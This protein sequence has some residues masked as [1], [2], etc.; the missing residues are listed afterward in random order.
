MI[1]LFYQTRGIM[2]KN[3]NKFLKLGIFII[4]VI[5]LS[6]LLFSVLIS[7]L[8]TK[9]RMFGDGLILRTLNYIDN[10]RLITKLELPSNSTHS[11]E[12][13][14][15]K[16]GSIA[17][18]QLRVSD[19][20]FTE[21]R[22]SDEFCRKKYTQLPLDLEGSIFQMDKNGE[23]IRDKNGRSKIRVTKYMKQEKNNNNC[24]NQ[25]R[26][27]DI[28]LL[29]KNNKKQTLFDSKISDFGGQ[30]VKVKK[31]EVLY[32]TIN[33]KIPQDT[34]VAPMHHYNIYLKLRAS[35]VLP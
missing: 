12:Y 35:T 32:I 26:Y 18:Y 33:T 19:F 14:A 16:K 3:T 31:D 1:S 6:L 29:I 10:Y 15:P 30:S 27:G 5:F 2:K 4:L 11:L 22:E 21:L 17:F 28:F 9:Y 20:N 24:R 25:Y 13:T 23:I 8:Q 34:K 7:D